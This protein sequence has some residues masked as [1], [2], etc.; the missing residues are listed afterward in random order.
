VATAQTAQTVPVVQA[1][2]AVQRPV[3]VVDW[4]GRPA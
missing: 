3:D 1:A 4:R 2:R